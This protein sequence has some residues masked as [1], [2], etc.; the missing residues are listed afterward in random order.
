MRRTSSFIVI[1]ALMVVVLLMAVGCAKKATP[2]PTTP[3][4]APKPTPTTPAASPTPTPSPS[5]TP[6]KPITLKFANFPPAPTF[7]CVSM[8]RWA[9]E[10]EKRTNGKVKVQTF[11]GGTLLGAKNMF[12]GVLA[13]TA[14]IGCDCTSYFPGRFPLLAG[15]DLPVGYT[16]ATQASHVLW[17]LIQ[18]FKPKS[19]ADFKVLHAYTCAPA[20]IQS[21]DPIRSLEDLKGYEL[22]ASGTGATILKALGAAAVG[23]PQSEVPEALQKGVIKGYASS[24]EVLMDFKY[25]EIVKYVT[26][27]PMFV[28]SFVVVMNKNSW[29]SLPDDVKE[30][31]SGLGEEQSVW[32]GQYMDKH[33][34]ESMKW[35][36]EKQGV[37]V[38]KL[39]PE[40]KARWD[41]KLKPL[42]DKWLEDTEAKGLPAKKFL[43]RL[44]ELQA[45][46][47]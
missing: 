30:V 25:A 9:D 3:P 40:E 45:K 24:R 5:P 1:I 32:T 18:E 28:V 15:N 7:P 6:V 11:P 33:V 2:S 20:Y 27:Y 44:Y 21:K 26:D 22:R 41:A 12:D 8:E 37:Q 4:P 16:S 10:V 39:S 29:N 31:L 36:Q 47:K 38:I 42:I 17:D 43:D 35:A 19:L 34:E 46:Y 13:G 23:M 14:D